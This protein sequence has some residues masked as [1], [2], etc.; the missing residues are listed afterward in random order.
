MTSELDCVKAQHTARKFWALLDY[1][2]AVL[3]GLLTED[4]Q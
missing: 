3:E 2:Q 4:V 1:T